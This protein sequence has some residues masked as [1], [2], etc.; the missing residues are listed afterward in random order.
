[1]PR[2]SVCVPTHEIPETEAFMKR[3]EKSLEKQT[4]Q[5]FELIVTKEGKMAKNTNA[6]IK[7]AKGEIIKILF[8]DDFLFDVDA[9]K[10]LDRYFV[11][12]WY[13]SACVHTSDGKN[14]SN[15]HYPSYNSDIRYG[16]NTIGSP[17]V[18]AFENDEP[19][20]F[21]EELSW[22]LDCD[23]YYRLH[24]R[25]GRPTMV[26]TLDIAIG[27]GEHQTTNLMPIED[28][29]LEMDYLLQKYA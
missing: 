10:N 28:K 6:A 11:G 13:A 17:S 4:F 21:D 3:L 23:L 8:M 1:M 9:L 20:L 22:L 26:N 18:V 2:I 27:L 7:Q 24:E 16:N 12:G 5:D 15:P 25:Y 14:F 19:L 29:K